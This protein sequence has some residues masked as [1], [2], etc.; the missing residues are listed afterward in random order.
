MIEVNRPNKGLNRDSSPIDQPNGT[1][2]Y[3]LNAINESTSGDDNFLSNEL[4]FEECDSLPE[5]YD[6][7]GSGYLGNG[8]IVLFSVSSEDRDWET[9]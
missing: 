3:A 7:I 5:G 4:G 6:V 8:D 9:H 2:T 1:Y